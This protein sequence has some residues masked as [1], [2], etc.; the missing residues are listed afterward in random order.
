MC[1]NVRSISTLRDSAV[2]VLGTVCVDLVGT[3]ILLVCLAVVAGQVGLD[4]CTDTDSVANLDCLDV[5]S[6]LDSLADNLVANADWCWNLTP[7]SCN[8]VAVRAANTATV[9]GDVNVPVL[10][11]LEL[12][13]Y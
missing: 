7:S 13:L 11:R 8:C 9:D 4:L 10:E 2:L 12:E 1:S 3:V 6:N 5:L